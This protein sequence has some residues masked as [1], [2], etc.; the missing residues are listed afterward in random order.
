MNEGFY[1]SLGLAARAGKVV[2]GAG[3]C[4]AGVKNGKVKLLILDGGV[5]A[6][7]K[8]AFAG[9]CARRGVDIMCLDDTDC[10]GQR[11]GKPGRKVI[12]IVS[13]EFAK[14]AKARAAVPG[15]E[16]FEQDKNT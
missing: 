12:G 2:Y 4:E 10:L 1:G 7:T 5:S 8:S 15:G 16:K 3:A 11:L 6:N 13:V 9:M 14:M